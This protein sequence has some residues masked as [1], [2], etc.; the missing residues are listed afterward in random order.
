MKDRLLKKYGMKIFLNK[1][2]K[3]KKNIH[4]AVREEMQR[5]SQ[6]HWGK[7][8]LTLNSNKIKSSYLNN[9]NPT[10]QTTYQM[11]NTKTHHHPNHYR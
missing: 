4:L 11:K 7:P 3:E 5:Q 10:N 9:L 1:K 6:V 8:L 2:Q